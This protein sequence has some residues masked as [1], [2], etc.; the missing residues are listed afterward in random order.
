M[1]R[2]DDAVADLQTL[3][4]SEPSDEEALYRRVEILRRAGRLEEALDAATLAVERCPTSAA[5]R[6]GRAVVHHARGASEQM[7]AD[8]EYAVQLT[9]AGIEQHPTQMSRRLELL[10]YLVA[11]DLTN[12]VRSVFDSVAERASDDDL[13]QLRDRLEEQ[14]S[15]LGETPAYRALLDRLDG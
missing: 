12:E 13:E 6:Q 10:T 11:L 15:A 8:L 7:R 2:L 4:E 1:G 3:L 14:R 5:L 9:R